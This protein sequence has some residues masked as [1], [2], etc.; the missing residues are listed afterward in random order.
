MWRVLLHPC[1][2]QYCCEQRYLNFNSA[3]WK[4]YGTT[5]NNARFAKEEQTEAVLLTKKGSVN[6][7]SL[8]NDEKKEVKKV[9]I[10]ETL[11]TFDSWSFHPM[12]NTATIE[13]KRDDMLKFFEHFKIAFDKLNLSE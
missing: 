10:D 11:F 7:F 3:F 6:P 12:D 1:R 13:V 8:V 4:K 5:H 9:L 2:D